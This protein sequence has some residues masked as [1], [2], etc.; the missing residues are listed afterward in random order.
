MSTSGSAG[1]RL[2][3]SA[4][5]LPQLVRADP[6]PTPAT[7]PP[8]E[9]GATKKRRHEKPGGKAK[10]GVKP[11]AGVEGECSEEEKEE[12]E[13]EQPKKK[14][15]TTGGKIKGAV[16]K[17]TIKEIPALAFIS[18]EELAAQEK[19]W[20]ARFAEIELPDNFLSPEQQAEQEEYWAARFAE[21]ELP[22]DFLSP[23][24]QAEQ[25]KYWAA[26]F[27]TIKLPDDFLSPEQQAE[28]E[29]YWA[30]HFAGLQLP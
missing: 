24:Q 17:P 21:I 15:K 1:I 23:E 13:D 22:D 27:A 29:E 26:H 2:R 8:T 3:R 25:E 5:Q 12:D 11:V 14:G 28:Q 20:A 7:E 9:H 4:A 16:N 6:N 30:A 18:P 19:Y 10:K